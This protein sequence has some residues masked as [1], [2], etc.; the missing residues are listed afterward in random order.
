MDTTQPTT[1]EGATAPRTTGTWSLG[2]RV[3]AMLVGV[4]LAVVVVAPTALSSKDLV[5]WAQS[6]TGLGLPG[7]WGTGAFVALDAAAVVCVGMVIVAAWRGETATAF[8]ILT[9]TFA[10]GSAFANYRHGETTPARDDEYFFPAMS[11]AGPAL[12]EV[13]L[14]RIRRWVSEQDRTRMTARPKFGARW[15]PG[16]ALTETL[17][18]WQ[19]SRREDIGAPQDAVEHARTEAALRGMGDP[20]AV[21]LAH[22]WLTD[23]SGAVTETAVHQWLARHRR[24]VSPGVVH[25]WF[26]EHHTTTTPGGGPPGRTNGAPHHIPASRTTPPPPAPAAPAAHR[27]DTT[28]QP[29]PARPDLSVVRAK[30]A[31]HQ[32]APLVVRGELLA[33]PADDPP[34]SR[35]TTTADPREDEAWD[36]A[37]AFTRDWHATRGPGDPVPRRPMAAAIREAHGSCSDARADRIRTAAHTHVL[38]TPG[39][40]TPS[41]ESTA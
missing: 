34:R 32:P 19:A 37:V 30:Q 26:T 27:T 21:R 16:V 40:E 4:A 9:W 17:R 31:A 38:A 1:A 18:A 7:L 35:R 22:Q 41:E 15:L 10:T 6:P 23:T 28:P 8:Q 25:Q 11:F 13:T 33:A 3:V 12:L 20:D 24:T 36:T 29:A 5:E 39:Q 14:A 2:L